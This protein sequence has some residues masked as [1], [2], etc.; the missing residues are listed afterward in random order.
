M[1]DVHDKAL[2]KAGITPDL[3]P[4]D[5]GGSLPFFPA[6]RVD[7]LAGWGQPPRRYGWLIAAGS[8]VLVLVGGFFSVR[9]LAR[10]GADVAV[11]KA[12]PPVMYHVQ[13]D[14]GSPDTR[15]V[16][17]VAPKEAPGR[18]DPPSFAVVEFL[19]SL[20]P[21]KAPGELRELE[22]REAA[23]QLHLQA[24]MAGTYPTAS[25]N[26]QAVKADSLINIPAGT[27]HGAIAFRVVSISDDAVTLAAEGI[28]IELRL[29]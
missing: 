26:D 18:D 1:K 25:I 24:I 27:R 6:G 12:P 20:P 3:L 5:V 23:R 9:F 4:V 8:A 11:P 14:P 13:H 10:A 28:E 17:E 29:E 2:E 7:P 22:I 16:I 15:V 21:A 19:E